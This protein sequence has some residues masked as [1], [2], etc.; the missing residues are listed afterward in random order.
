MM[1]MIIAV[2]VPLALFTYAFIGW[3]VG[4]VIARRCSFAM[5]P[6]GVIAGA[7]WPIGVPLV[8]GAWVAARISKRWR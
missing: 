7:L 2:A 1:E 4:T 8:L 3:T 5:E 6:L